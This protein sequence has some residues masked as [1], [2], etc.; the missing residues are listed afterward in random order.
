MFADI[1]V[2]IIRGEEEIELPGIDAEVPGYEMYVNMLGKD[3]IKILGNAQ[4]GDQIAIKTLGLNHKR[5]R[6]KIL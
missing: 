3:V 6:Q 1:A 2:Y 5:H 4:A